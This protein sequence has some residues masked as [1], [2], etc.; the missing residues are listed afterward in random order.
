M[1]HNKHPVRQCFQFSS[2]SANIMLSRSF[3]ITFASTGGFDAI[4]RS[5]IRHHLSRKSHA[6]KV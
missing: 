3:A 2:I 4:I 6:D 1:I 5:A